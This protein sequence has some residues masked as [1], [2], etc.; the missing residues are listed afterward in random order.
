MSDLE[1]RLIETLKDH[2]SMTAD[3]IQQN[4]PIRFGIVEII[5]HLKDLYHEG[6][7]SIDVSDMPPLYSLPTNPKPA[8]GE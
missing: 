8:G 1:A 4:L 7:V 3:Q 5:S 2:G 6:R